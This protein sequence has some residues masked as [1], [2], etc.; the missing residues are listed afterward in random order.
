MTL[1]TNLRKLVF[2]IALAVLL[3][4]SVSLVSA[5]ITNVTL[6]EPVN[7]SSHDRSDSFF[8]F[9]STSDSDSYYSCNLSIDSNFV[10]GD[11]LVQNNTVTSFSHT[12][13]DGTHNWSVWCNDTDSSQSSPLRYFTVDTTPPDV[14]LIGP[15]NNYNSS[16]EDIGFEF[17]VTDNVTDS[18]DC[19]VYIDGTLN[20]TF[21][22]LSNGEH[23]QFS[24]DDVETGFHDWNVSCVDELDNTGFSETRNFTVD[25]QEPQISLHEPI[26]GGNSSSSDVDFN[27]TVSDDLA[28][29]L[30]CDLDIDGS[31]ER[32][33]NLTNGTSNLFSVSGVVDGVH[34]WNVSCIDDAGNEGVSSLRNFTVDTTPPNISITNESEEYIS[35][36]NFEVCFESY[37][38]YF[39]PSDCS[40]I[41]DGEMIDAVSVSNEGTGNFEA[42][43]LSEGQHDWDLNCSDQLENMYSISKTTIVDFSDPDVSL[44]SPLHDAV[45]TPDDDFEFKVNDSVPETFCSLYIDGSVNKTDDFVADGRTTNSFSASDLSDDVHTWWVFCD[46]GLGHGSDSDSR[47]VFVDRSG[48]VISIDEPSDGEFI[49]QDSTMITF[50]AVDEK[51]SLDSCEFY[52]DGELNQTNT[53]ANDSETISFPVNNISQDKHSWRLSCNDTNGFVSNTTLYDL[54]YDTTRPSIEEATGPSIAGVDVPVGFSLKAHDEIS[55]YL[56]CTLNIDGSSKKSSEVPADNSSHELSHRFDDGGNYSWAFECTDG[57]GNTYTGDEQDILI[58]DTPPVILNRSPDDGTIIKSSRV[59]FSVDLEDD[60]SGSNDMNCSFYVDGEHVGSNDSDGGVV[61]FSK[62]F[63]TDGEYDWSAVCYDDFENKQSLNSHSFVVDVGP[64]NPVIRSLP[65]VTSNAS[66]DIVGMVDTIFADDP[67]DWVRIVVENKDGD[68]RTANTTDK[69]LGNYVGDVDVLGLGSDSSRVRINNTLEAESLVDETRFVAFS[70]HNRSDYRFYNITGVT[71]MGSSLRM[72][73]TPALPSNLSSYSGDG[74]IF[75]NPAPTGWFNI[76]SLEL[77]S[78]T[79]D[80]TVFGQ[81]DD[82][83]G[84]VLSSSIF[85][86]DASPEFN[87]SKLSSLSSKGDFLTDLSSPMTFS[88]HDD[89]GI[90]IQTLLVNISDANSTTSYTISGDSIYNESM[91]RHAINC[92]TSVQPL[93]STECSF[94]PSL[95]DGQYN[96]TFSVNDSFN[97]RAV[98]SLTDNFTVKTVVDPVQNISTHEDTSTTDD[99]INVTWIPPDDPYLDYYNLTIFIS[100]GGEVVNSFIVSGDRSSKVLNVDDLTYGE[101]LF[102]RIYAVDELG[103]QGSPVNA[104]GE[105][106]V[107]ADDTPPVNQSIEIIADKDNGFNSDSALQ[108]SFNFTDNESGVKYYDYA[109]GTAP[110][111]SGICQSGWNDLVDVTRVSGSTVEDTLTGLDLAENE[112]Y[113]LSVRAQSDYDYAEL[114]SNYH[115]STPVTVDTQA[116]D[117]GSIDYTVGESTLSTVEIDYDVGGDE[118]GLRSDSSLKYKRAPLSDSVCGSFSSWK[119]TNKSVDDVGSTSFALPDNGCYKFGLFVHDMAGNERIYERGS[120]KNLSV[121]TTPPSEVVF[122]TESHI[123]HQTSFAFDWE[124]SVDPESGLDRYEY[125]LST[126]PSS[127]RTDVVG[128]TATEKSSVTLDFPPE[129]LTNGETYYLS[130]RAYNGMN[131]STPVET[132]PSI[133]YFDT[134]T[135]EPLVPVSVASDTNGSDGWVDSNLANDSTVITLSGEAGLANCVWN[136]GDDFSYVD[137]G[138]PSCPEISPGVYECEVP[139]LSEGVYD[140]HV[141]CRDDNGNAQSFDENTDLTFHKEMRSPILNITLPEA[142]S[143]QISTVD[144]SFNLTDASLANVT[145]HLVDVA[146]GE[147]INGSQINFTGLSSGSYNFTMNLTG[148]DRETRLMMTA[149]D[150]HARSSGRNTTFL[151]N[152]N[153]PFVKLRDDESLNSFNATALFVNDN[154][155]INLSAYF[156]NN[157]SYNLTNSSGEIVAGCDETLSFDSLQ[158]DSESLSLDCSVDKSSLVDD[159]VYTLSAFASNSNPAAPAYELN[160]SIIADL[161]KPILSSGSLSHEPNTV[162][163]TDNLSFYS[164][165]LDVNEMDM[166]MFNYSVDGGDWEQLALGDGVEKVSPRQ[167]IPEEARYEATLVPPSL[168]ANAS[169]DYQWI[170]IDAAGNRNVTGIRSSNITNRKPVINASS[171]T[172]EGLDGYEFNEYVSFTDA[173]IHSQSTEDSFSCSLNDTT[174]FDV[175]AFSDTKCRI[176]WSNSTF[177]KNGTYSLNL[178]VFDLKDDRPLAND[179]TVLNITILPTEYQ[180]ISIDSGFNSKV[181]VTYSY[182]GSLVKAES[183]KNSHDINALIEKKDGY[184]VNIAS[185]RLDVTAHNVSSSENSPAFYFR[186]YYNTSS[187]RFANDS[188]GDD[189]TFRPKLAYAAEADFSGVA[190]YTV[191]FNISGLDLDPSRLAIFKYNNTDQGIEYTNASG[192][193]KLDTHILGDD[194]AYATVDGFSAFVLAEKYVDDSD[195]DS[196]DNS[197]SSSSSSGS[198]GGFV[199]SVP[200]STEPNCSD[201]IKNQDE[202][203]IDCGGVCNKSCTDSFDPNESESSDTPAPSCNDSIQN[204]GEDGVDCGGPCEP[205]QVATCYDGIRNQ[206]EDDV[207]CGG[208]C[209]PCK[210]DE[211][212]PAP[213]DPATEKPESTG[214]PGFVWILLS[215]FAILGIGAFAFKTHGFSF[216]HEHVGGGNDH[217]IDNENIARVARFIAK[218]LDGTACSLDRVKAHLISHGIDRKYVEAA[219]YALSNTTKVGDVLSYLDRYTQRG[220]SVVELQKWLVDRGVPAGV[221]AVA[222]DIFRDTGENN[223]LRKQ[224]FSENVA[225]TSKI[226]QPA[227]DIDS[228][229]YDSLNHKK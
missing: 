74:H 162:Y 23:L 202:V 97:H 24:V 106:V 49:D 174:L 159:E 154:F 2:L 86:D 61:E 198:S 124:D 85:K 3:T 53:T 95:A 111:V 73:I 17:N 37:D 194:V 140:F 177:A 201:G 184:A 113:Y 192:Y 64:D 114:W 12:V 103:N 83:R 92:T 104:S 188:L 117:G 112:K 14:G 4:L 146:T 143:T 42:S 150:E 176:W 213:R 69:R 109:V 25:T 123:T 131:D 47:D 35:E 118:H 134:I 48:P 189:L 8:N 137:S 153:K 55:P 167:W 75:E 115:S 102:A 100:P 190:D 158:N 161:E 175:S 15:S 130:V 208:P 105:G 133:L 40:F 218:E 203:G 160:Y 41:L 221:V 70:F 141:A 181:D 108:L 31:T 6:H 152:T 44:V 204:Q 225:D 179:S 163:E 217:V 126:D 39:S 223:P 200:P 68:I 129:N 212:A 147:T 16:S 84:D 45:I 196:S 182:N 46:D 91:A 145:A 38:K 81:R 60:V 96:L 89:Y 195:D 58:D 20:R 72:N 187:I 205:C 57:G 59:D 210:D 199:G 52:F 67:F 180:N 27:F 36:D 29:S 110:C 144:V 88:V 127:S 51:S 90:D 122:V 186:K 128:W 11:D 185:D 193:G 215:V 71:D 172:L 132:S 30:D 136:L 165:W 125:A 93:D 101:R 228:S 56:D 224:L 66:I 43:N 10:D 78:G 33:D 229:L 7:G 82:V 178:T 222:Y 209:P 216:N 227:Q 13:A 151:T 211:P 79:N 98:V 21:D 62:D 1:E 50:S 28:S 197:G 149:I 65:E 9:T 76:S 18:L 219:S 171:S 26:P 32:S 170:A 94:L 220:Y 63:S 206:G 34:R 164:G 155:T 183:S 139:D 226:F 168:V 99:E 138:L 156:F 173:D 169:I 77:F 191:S 166:V 54:Y 80:F 116:P 157:I 135:P 19:S 214:M 107:F 121:D 142:E 119:A 207:D 22:N 148:A 5:V 87:L 120:V